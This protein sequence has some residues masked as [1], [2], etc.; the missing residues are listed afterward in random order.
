LP[1]VVARLLLRGESADPGLAGTSSS[2]TALAFEPDCISNTARAARSLLTHDSRECATGAD[3]KE[4]TGD[5]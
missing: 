1:P 4:D 5:E 3:F 2:C